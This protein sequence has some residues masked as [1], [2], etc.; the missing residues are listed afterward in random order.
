MKAL[1]LTNKGVEEISSLEIKKLTKAK[2]LSVKEKI[3]E[4]D[5]SKTELIK[6]VYMGR[7]FNRCV[8]V[9]D[10]FKI[11]KISD[12]KIP[13]L[14][15]K[16]KKI[17]VECERNGEHSFTS[18]DVA[19]K[20][21]KELTEKYSAELD[22]KNPDILIH[23]QIQKETCW[24]GIDYAGIDLGKRFYRI[25]LGKEALR[26]NIAAA[27]LK[28]IDYKNGDVLLDPFCRQGIIPIEAG[29]MG[30]KTSVNKFIKDKLA[31]T[32]MFDSNLEKY[33]K[34]VKLKGEITAL[35]N[36]FKHIHNSK[37]NAKIAGIVKEISFS[38]MELRWIDSK[39]KDGKVDKIVTLLP[40]YDDYNQFFYQ[41]EFIL[42][43]KG[44]VLV[45]MIKSFE[46]VKKAA[47]K[48]KFKFLEECSVMQGEQ[49]LKVFVFEK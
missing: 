44:L 25:F 8:E 1:V 28:I 11:K 45:C 19:K 20:L 48:Y 40:V 34:T 9:L 35:D 41:A 16:D 43:K 39:F 18:F 12:I 33:D 46:E 14:K 47:S 24:V 38:R 23:V 7:T 6:L 17:K 31:V 27:L 15:L 2:I 42:K 32:K 10:K 22:F 13:D 36:N 26:G 3:V 37:K 49:E 29:L 5:C 30:T 4:I 21:N